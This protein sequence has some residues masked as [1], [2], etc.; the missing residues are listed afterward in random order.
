[1]ILFSLHGFPDIIQMIMSLG[2]VN[3]IVFT[4][5]QFLVVPNGM[6][7]NYF[8]TKV[9]YVDELKENI[10]LLFNCKRRCRSVN[11]HIKTR[12]MFRQVLRVMPLDLGSLFSQDSHL[13]N[14]INGSAGEFFVAVRM[15]AS[16]I[17]LQEYC[18]CTHCYWGS[19]FVSVN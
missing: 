17:Q 15:S 13:H 9:S 12:L 16:A 3:L 19:R 8:K 4:L 7:V 18:L 6:K 11:R 5:H 2:R 10:S 14:D 1:M